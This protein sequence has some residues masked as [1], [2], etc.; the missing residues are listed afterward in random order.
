[1]FFGFVYISVITAPVWCCRLGPLMFFF[2]FIIYI[3]Y[4]YLINSRA[5]SLFITNPTISGPLSYGRS[6][7]SAVVSEILSFS[8]LNLFVGSVNLFLT[9]FFES[10]VD[11]WVLTFFLILEKR[12]QIRFFCQLGSCFGSDAVPT[13][14]LIVFLACLCPYMAPSLLLFLAVDKKVFPF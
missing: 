5:L 1:M 9:F 11:L 6:G 7:S 12:F 2:W 10:Y 14:L 4:G 13:S 3:F 8:I